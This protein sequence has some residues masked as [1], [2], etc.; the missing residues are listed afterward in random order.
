MA[1]SAKGDPASLDLRRLKLRHLSTVVEVARAGSLTRAALALHVTVPAVSKTLREVR[2]ML[3]MELF[4]PRH[5]T[6]QLTPQGEVFVAHARASLEAVRRGVAEAQ[7][8]VGGQNRSIRVAVMPNVA[9]NFLPAVLQELA[10]IDVL[11]CIEVV[12][13]SN[14]IALQMLRHGEIDGVLGRL[15][16]PSD[17]VGLHFQ[18]LY[19]DAVSPVVRRGHPLLRVRSRAMPDLLPYTVLMPPARTI[20]R[21]EVEH[22]LH[23]GGLDRLP[24]RIESMSVELPRRL[25]LTTDAVW[26]AQLESV[27]PDL[28]AGRLQLLFPALE[29]PR[30]PVGITTRP[31]IT[32][33]DAM[34][35]FIAAAQKA[36]S[37]QGRL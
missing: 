19:V 4:E 35:S 15:A 34:R 1:R 30:S 5:G 6:T 9:L 13:G 22:L 31:G 32:P 14:P 27:A 2:T 26:F 10:R 8:R 17:M 7:Q 18:H 33:S 25:A 36:A 28:A 3:G 23:A 12:G 37:V 16:S 24:R 20:A 21:D 29:A 11:D